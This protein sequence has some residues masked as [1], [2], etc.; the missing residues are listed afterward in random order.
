MRKQNKKNA[1]PSDQENTSVQHRQ[2]NP[3]CK[4]YTTDGLPCQEFY[5]LKGSFIM[6]KH[7]V[8]EPLITPEEAVSLKNELMLGQ[9]FVCDSLIAECEKDKTLHQMWYK[10][11][12]WNAGRIHGIRS[13]RLR[14]KGVKRA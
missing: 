14:R 1:R 12:I 9:I 10:A 6:K 3:I 2:E 8:T 13:E 4:Y 7:D 5:N 11:V